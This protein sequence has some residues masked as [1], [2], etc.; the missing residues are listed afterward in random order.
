[1]FDKIKNKIKMKSTPIE[2]IEDVKLNEYLSKFNCSNCHNHCR[3]DK[4]K[5]GGGIQFRE[6]KTNEYK[7]TN[8]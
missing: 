1:M 7:A 3:L 5:C 6:E 4:I 8:I 2:N